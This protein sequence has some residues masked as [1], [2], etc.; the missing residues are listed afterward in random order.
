M[1]LRAKNVKK[2]TSVTVEDNELSGLVFNSVKTSM[3]CLI[4]L[5]VHKLCTYVHNGHFHLLT[6]AKHG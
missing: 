3:F 2:G 5:S 1:L 6:D 4:L